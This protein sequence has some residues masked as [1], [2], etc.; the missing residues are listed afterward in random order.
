MWSFC[1]WSVDLTPFKALNLKFEFERILLVNKDKA[2]FYPSTRYFIGCKHSKLWHHTCWNVLWYEHK[3]FTWQNGKENVP[4][5]KECVDGI[6]DKT[7]L[8]R[9]TLLRASFDS[10]QHYWRDLDE[11]SK[12]AATAFFSHRVLDILEF[13]V[14]L[15][16]LRNWKETWKWI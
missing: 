9:E 13:N 3:C 10:L 1:L 15:S 2:D 16:L 5:I 8:K 4:L 7:Y 12:R 6:R 14:V 11:N